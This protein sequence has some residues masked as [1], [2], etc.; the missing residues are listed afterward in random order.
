MIF[1]NSRFFFLSK[2]NEL[3]KIIFLAQI[4]FKNFFLIQIIFYAEKNF[5]DSGVNFL[6]SRL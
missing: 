2:T 3:F 4:F 6:D 5:F 1:I